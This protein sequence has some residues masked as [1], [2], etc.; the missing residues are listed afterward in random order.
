MDTAVDQYALSPDLAARID[1]LELRSNVRDLIDK[2][3]T[4]ILNDPVAAAC[5]DRVR[6]AILRLAQETEG[7]TKG[8]T[9]GVLLGRDPV[10][11][12]A[13]LAPKLLAL[14]EFLLGRAPVLSQLE[15]SVRT[16]GAAPLQLHADNGWFP[17]PFPPW[18]ILATACWV[19]DEFTLEGGCTSV[20][21]GSHKLQRRPRPG[22]VEACEGAVPILAP[23]GAI[24][25]WNGSVWHA[26]FPRK[27][28]GQR[29]VL[30]MTYT[31]IGFQPLEDY[32]HLDEQWLKDKPSAMRE[33]LGRDL[34]FGSATPTGGEANFPR[35][36][37]TYNL[38]NGTNLEDIGNNLA[39]LYRGE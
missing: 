28:P 10:F 37:H 4:V 18:E 7:K 26:N 11:A 16:L 34:V 38:V 27:I 2:G 3:Y 31:R 17:E 9:A 12:E 6:D 22:E 35:F 20:V 14:L 30:H 29:V 36:I 25:L 21:P 23:K 24:C 5:T 1:A 15:G 13:V 8:H 32:S 19:T 39:A 33:V